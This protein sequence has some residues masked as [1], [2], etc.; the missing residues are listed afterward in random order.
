M[1]GGCLALCCRDHLVGRPL[2]SVRLH[3]K[4]FGLV[5]WLDRYSSPALASELCESFQVLGLQ[6]LGLETW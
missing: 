4:G 6:G 5:F 1:T 2:R 3:G